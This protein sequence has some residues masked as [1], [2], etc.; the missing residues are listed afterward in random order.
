MAFA[1][2]HSLR[3]ITKRQK[4][5]TLKALCLHF[6]GR[7]FELATTTILLG[8]SIH[9]LIWPN[10]M[11]ASLFDSLTTHIKSSLF[12]LFF[13]CFGSLRLTA[14]LVNGSWPNYGPF[15]RAAGALCGAMVFGNMAAALFAANDTIGF[16]PPSIPVYLVLAL[17]EL[18][19]IY[20]AL[21]LVG[22][23]GVPT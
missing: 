16:M 3:Q 20:R 5:L 2:A 11:S 4:K 13:L 23:H 7:L 6:E 10:A 17:F 19:S 14:L 15:L 12:G 8:L 21:V 22:R 18:I 9:V 1:S